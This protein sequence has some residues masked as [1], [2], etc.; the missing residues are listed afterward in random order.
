LKSITSV[1]IVLLTFALVGCNYEKDVGSDERG[2]LRQYV[3]QA[4]DIEQEMATSVGK[5]MEAEPIVW[6]EAAGNA[7]TQQEV[8]D[9]YTRY[10]SAA[11]PH[12]SE[13]VSEF[14]QLNP[15]ETAELFHQ[16]TLSALRGYEE[17]MESGISTFK[18][19]D[20]Q[21]MLGVFEK[22]DNA[23]ESMESARS[24]LDRLLKITD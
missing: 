23:D 4:F 11:L 6:D 14:E 17:V 19:G 10:F 21:G 5:K 7:A 1:L 8:I 3:E 24:E 22:M 9:A 12:M 18:R 20:Y 15:P 2:K 16:S 13:A